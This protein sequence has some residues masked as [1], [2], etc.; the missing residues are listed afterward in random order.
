MMQAT[1]YSGYKLLHDGVLALADVEENGIVVDVEYCKKQQLHLKRRVEKLEAKIFKAPVIKKWRK[2]YGAK[3]NLDSKAQVAKVF[4]IDSAKQEVM[5]QLSDPVI[6]DIILRERLNK[7]SNTYIANI[8]RETVDGLLHPFFHLHTTRSI[9]GSSS[10]IN[11]QNQPVRIPLI[12]KIVRRAFK[13]RQG[14]LIIEVD[15]SGQEVKIAACNHKDPEMIKEINDPSRDMHRDM[16][17]MCYKVP[18]EQMTK[19]IRYCGKNQFIFPQFYGDYYVHNATD[20]WNSITTLKLKLNDSTPLLSHLKKQG[21]GTYKKFESHIKEVENYF[22]KEKFKVYAEWKLDIWDEYCRTGEVYLKSGFV[23]KGYMARN[24]VINMPIQG[25]AFHCLLWSLIEINNWLKLTN[26]KT[27]IIGQIHDS[28]V[29]DVHCKE[30]NEVMQKCEQVMTKDIVTYWPWIIVPLVI[31]AE[32][33][34]VNGSWYE[35]EEVKKAKC[36]KCG[37][38]W[39]WLKN[40]S[41]WE[42]PVCRTIHEI[43]F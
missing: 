10:N 9:R 2:E 32:F 43:P 34:P 37:S 17:M 1:T 40:N 25:P 4:K 30:V 35:K 6:Q 28:M 8:V 41:Q 16:A 19:D 18:K 5:E 11:F 38:D 20:L 13:A 26:K 24:K 3:F 33:T 7:A 22:W 42:C 36:I 39:M 27:K 15:Y 23:C 14:H 29:M 31:D 21:I 12:R